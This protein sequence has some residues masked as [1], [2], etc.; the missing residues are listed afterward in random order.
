MISYRCSGISF[1]SFLAI[2]VLSGC[3]SSEV[4]T[5]KPL[6]GPSIHKMGVADISLVKEMTQMTI[7]GD[8]NPETPTAKEQAKAWN[9]AVI[10]MTPKCLENASIRPSGGKYGK[11]FPIPRTCQTCNGNYEACH[12]ERKWQVIL[13][14][15]CTDTAFDIRV[16]GKPDQNGQADGAEFTDLKPSCEVSGGTIGFR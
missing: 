11:W 7:T 6:N 14:M 5:K 10:N 2:M 13:T 12:N 4:S 3:T 16:A 9:L 1:V 8:Q 15:V